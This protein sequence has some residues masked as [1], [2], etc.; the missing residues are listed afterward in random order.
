MLYVICILI[1]LPKVWFLAQNVFYCAH[2]HLKRMY[3]A[4][5]VYNNKVKFIGNV[6]HT[7][8]I[9]IFYFY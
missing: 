8:C 9:L 3:S 5:V 6:V 4:V 1:K 7:F 2:L